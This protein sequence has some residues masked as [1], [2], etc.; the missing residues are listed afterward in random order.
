MTIEL[1]K[2]IATYLGAETSKDT[3]VLAH[4]FAVDA[5][6]HDEGRTMRCVPTESKQPNHTCARPCLGFS[7]EANPNSDS[8]SGSI[9]SIGMICRG[10]HSDE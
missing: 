2:P 3:E 6:V 5:V 7:P 9:S 10:S 8:A 4:C 1:P